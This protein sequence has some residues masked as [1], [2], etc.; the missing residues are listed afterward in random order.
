MNFQK[1]TTIL[2]FIKI[3]VFEIVQ[4]FNV[5]TWIFVAMHDTVLTL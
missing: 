4:C 3:N 2:A 1:D 5:N